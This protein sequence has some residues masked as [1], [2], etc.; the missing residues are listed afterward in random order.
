MQA[1]EYAERLAY[2]ADVAAGALNGS[3]GADEDAKAE[4]V[5]A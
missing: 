1:A 5:A 2:G 4:P 3:D